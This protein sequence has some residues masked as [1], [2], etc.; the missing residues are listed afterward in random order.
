MFEVEYDLAK[1]MGLDHE[2]PFTNNKEWVSHRLKASNVSFDDLNKRH[3]IY[4]TQPMQYEK[5]L[6]EG[7]NTPSG[8][9]ELYSQKLKDTGYPPLP[10]P[11]DLDKESIPSTVANEEY[12]LIGTTRR[13]DAY[14]HTQFRNIP[15]LRKR[16]PDCLLRINPFDASNRGISDGDMTRVKSPDGKISIKARLTDEIKKEAIL[17]DFGWGNP[18]DGGA[19]VNTLT[20][21]KDRDQIS[22]STSNHR[23]RCQ[24]SKETS[25]SKL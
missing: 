17:I 13:S 12:P 6:T 3:I 2:F 20:S 21:D 5:Y 19:N 1:R 11:K 14:T 8:K 25:F 4:A 7:F 22:C 24:V 9:V 16:D 23:F 18:G 15:E 10:E